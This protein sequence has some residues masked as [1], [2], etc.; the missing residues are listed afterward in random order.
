MMQVKNEMLFGADEH[1]R[2][3]RDCQELRR[4]YLLLEIST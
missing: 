2:E 1:A 3:L 4:K